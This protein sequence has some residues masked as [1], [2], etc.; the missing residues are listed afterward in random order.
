MKTRYKVV[1]ALIM[2]VGILAI[3]I[4]K[5]PALYMGRLAQSHV[6]SYAKKEKI[7]PDNQ[8]VANAK[9]NGN[10]AVKSLAE[11]Q[12]LARINEKVTLR[13]FITIPAVKLKLPIYEGASNKVLA[14][15]AGT[16]KTG[17]QMGKR[18]YAVGA[19][20]MSDNTTYFS[21]LQDRVRPGMKIYIQNDKK[22]FE[23]RVKAK[24]VISQ[25]RTNVIEDWHQREPI[26][27]LITCYEKPP[28]FTGATERVYVVG[29]LVATKNIKK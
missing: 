25:Y 12:R 1:A 7:V 28:Y 29:E 17:Q 24:N 20:N 18:N 10:L 11:L 13:G 26:I 4:G 27:T 15:G 8:D 21:P 3:Y 23:Y 19:H 5:N 9:Y 16:L 2:I 6:T 14:L 22:R